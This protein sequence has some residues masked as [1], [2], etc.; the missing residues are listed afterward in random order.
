MCYGIQSDAEGEVMSR[1]EKAPML[2]YSDSFSKGERA[3]EMFVPN[4]R[5]A[6][7]IA[8]ICLKCPL[9]AKK[10]NPTSCKRYEEER[11]KIK[12]QKK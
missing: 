5:H 2:K 10:C 6:D 9:P 12:E 4:E 1:T 7:P 8:L 3:S 11:R